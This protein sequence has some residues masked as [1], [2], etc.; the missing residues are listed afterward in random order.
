M[1]Q[2]KTDKD[3]ATI[4]AM[5][6][7]KYLM[8]IKNIA[9]IPADEVPELL[10]KIKAGDQKSLEKLVK[11]HLGIVVRIAKEHQTEG[12][13]LQDLI[14]EGNLALIS[15]AQCFDCNRTN[16]FESYAVIAIDNCIK[17]TL[18]EQARIVRLPRNEILGSMGKIG[19]PY[20]LFDTANESTDPML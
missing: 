14:H 10:E 3:P 9:P 6:L 4:D 15:A 8:E 12:I 18:S 2:L 19:K 20:T 13:S 16:S 5:S 1:R 17:Q 7:K 11:A